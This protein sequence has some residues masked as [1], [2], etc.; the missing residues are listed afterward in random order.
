MHGFQQTKTTANEYVAE[1]Q[2]TI[3]TA[4]QHVRK[5]LNVQHE[6]QKEYYNQ[7]VHGKPYSVKDLVWLY[8]PVVAKGKS[9]KLHH[10]WLG[11]YRIINKLYDITYRA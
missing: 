3:S 4:Y 8:S 7:K 10:P 2:K 5:K 9:K 11:Q 1:L 6:K